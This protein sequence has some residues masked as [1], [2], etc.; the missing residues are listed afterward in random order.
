MPQSTKDFRVC[1]FEPAPHGYIILLD[2]DIGNA[3]Q[4]VDGRVVENIIQDGSSVVFDR[5]L[6]GGDTN[7]NN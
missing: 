2:V 1:L 5:I 4:F 6:D 3:M 7:N